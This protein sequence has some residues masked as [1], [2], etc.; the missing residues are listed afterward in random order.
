MRGILDEIILVPGPEEIHAALALPDFDYLA[1]WRKMVPE[2][3]RF[4]SNPKQQ[5]PTPAAIL[6]LLFPQGEA[7]RIILTRRSENLRGHGGQI[8]FPGGRIEETD[9]DALGAALRE[10]REELGISTDEIVYLG[11]LTPVYI[12]GTHFMVQP[13][14]GMLAYEPKWQPDAHEVAEVFSMSLSELLNPT[15]K[16]VSRRPVRGQMVSVPFYEING[17]EVW[18]AT[19]LILSELE[20][21]LNH[22]ME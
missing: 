9:T 6:I 15:V 22:V 2:R 16:K 13:I 18:G 4:S 1:A 10:T 19:A 21:R 7:W 14:V 12:S 5:P 3:R 11:E 20:W 8:S 17:H